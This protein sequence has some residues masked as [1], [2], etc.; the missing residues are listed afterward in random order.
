[1]FVDYVQSGLLVFGLT[2]NAYNNTTN[3]PNSTQAG[4]SPGDWGGVI[5]N[6]AELSYTGGTGPEDN[7]TSYDN[8]DVT[9]IN[10]VGIPMLLQL[11]T[12]SIQG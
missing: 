1:M 9:A 7:G 3:N 2:T 5:W 12:H 11:M 4:D 10:Q 6:Q 8:I